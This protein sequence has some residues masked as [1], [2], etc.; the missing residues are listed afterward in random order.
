MNLRWPRLSIRGQV[1]LAGLAAVA[2][3]AVGLLLGLRAEQ[4]YRA[5][6][7]RAA[8]VQA[9]ILAASVTAALAFDDRPT[10]R[11]YVDA[12]RAN[13]RI[14]AAA[15]YDTEGGPLVTYARRPTSP[16]PARLVDT[17]AAFRQGA[18][19]VSVPVSEQGV[20][21]GAV[22]LRTAREPF[23]DFLGRH[24]G[25]AVLT[26]VSLL[27]LGV[28]TRSAAQLQRRAGE[29]AEANEKLTVE[30]RERARAEEALRQ[31][32]KMEALGQLTGGIA[33]DFNNLLQVVHGAFELIRRKPAE[34]E[35]VAVW[36]GN[37]LQA[38]ERGASLTRQ[39][40]AFS[41]AQKLELRPFIVSELIADMRDLITRSLG[42]D[43]ELEFRLDDDALPVLS[44]RTQLELAVLNMAIN[45]RDAMPD[46]GRLV[47][48]TE[49][50][51]V[52]PGHPVLDPD[53]YVELSVSDTGAGMPPEVA[54][55]AFDPFFTTKGVGKGTGLG[56]SQVYG[57]ARQA[58]GQATI[59]SEP[60]QGTTVRL[61]LRRSQT[62]VEAVQA[63][64]SAQAPVLAPA[65]GACVMV[66]DDDAEVRNL[67]RDTLELLGYRVIAADGGAR[68][69]EML[70]QDQPDLV[71]M[72]FAMP[73]MN[74]AE[75]AALARERWPGL[76][77]V[78]ASGYADSAAV[79]AALGGQAVILRKPFEMD[80]L[81]RTVA[82]GLKAQDPTRSSA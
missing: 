40:L 32:Q 61:L 19:E 52:P 75:A 53:A 46:G 24:S 78:F 50:I 58:G 76:P 27:M 15:V 56:L 20:R 31:S 17:V 30:M 6:A 63:G 16:P 66:V 14:A 79:E 54:E 3:L 11:E 34:T 13:R 44:D 29:L 7:A 18:A 77:I 21:L 71:L 43:I 55:R 39:L 23:G 82:E 5:Q 70:A 33:H 45:A 48:A 68:A 12:L 49:V 80:D 37:G 47:I 26:V 60:G 74:G 2:L 35:K 57:V 41:R 51:Q 73:G 64:R 42:G 22:Y 59:D 38:A 4:V 62:P 36:A 8:V 10:M 65:E 9:E 69:L 25:L 1:N 28:I 67:V 81:A 72:D